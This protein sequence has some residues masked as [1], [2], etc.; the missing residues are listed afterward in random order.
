MW[1]ILSIGEAHLTERP[2]Q[3]GEGC[4]RLIHH[5]GET[6]KPLIHGL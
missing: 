3:T 6:G 1:S 5:W 4:N 2:E